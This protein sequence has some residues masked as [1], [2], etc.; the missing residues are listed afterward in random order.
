MINDRLQ[1]RDTSIRHQPR[2]RLEADDTI[3]AARKTDRTS[4]VAADPEVDVASRDEDGCARG[5]AAGGE[6]RGVDV[7]HPACGVGQGCDT[8]TSRCGGAV[9]RLPSS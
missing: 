4:L 1:T 2:S 8:V 9:T 6:A 5:R 3:T 7:V